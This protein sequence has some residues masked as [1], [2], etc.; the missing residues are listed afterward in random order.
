MMIDLTYWLSV[1]YKMNYFPILFS[2]KLNSISIGLI[3]YYFDGFHID[4]FQS[5]IE[6]KSNCYAERS[7]LEKNDHGFFSSSLLVAQGNKCL[8]GL[9]PDANLFFYAFN[10]EE[11]ITKRH[12]VTAIDWLVD[13]G[14]QI[15]CIP[16]GSDVDEPEIM[17]SVDRAVASGILV[18]AASGNEYPEYVLFPAQ[19]PNVVSVGAIDKEYRM[20]DDCCRIPKPDC[21]LPGLGIPGLTSSGDIAYRNGT[22]VAC[23]IATGLAANY[24][25]NTKQSLIRKMDFIGYIEEVRCLKS[26]LV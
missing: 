15:I 18:L 14:V 8:K 3:D 12:L 10:P 24:L 26:I 2:N 17:E 23:V 1:N 5:K 21:W 13:Q 7:L 22:S 16:F 6:F 11:H 19:Y 25:V 20:L 9:V 4:L